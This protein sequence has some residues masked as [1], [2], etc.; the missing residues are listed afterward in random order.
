MAET[1]KTLVTRRSCRS[2]LQD[3]VPEE[4][5]ERILRAGMYAPTAMGKQSPVIVCVTN[6]KIR[7]RME[8]L[9]R[10][11]KGTD[12][13]PFYG[14][15]FVM[16]VLADKN[17]GPHVYDGSLVMGNMMN[18]AADLGI[19]TCWIHQ[20][21]EAYET[22]EGKALLKELGVEGDLEGIGHMIFG[23]PAEDGF[24]L[25]VPRKENYVIRVK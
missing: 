24:R 16:L 23:Y 12:G 15:P 11:A 4:I 8:D 5:I 18:E 17:I 3:E 7:D 6:K 19:G 25:L 13:N 2:Y 1:L 10:K 22:E 14:A 9:D 20:A 21:K